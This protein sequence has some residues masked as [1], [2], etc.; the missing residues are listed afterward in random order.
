MGYGSAGVTKQEYGAYLAASIAYLMNRQRDAVGLLAFADRIVQH[1]PASGRPGHL[2]R[3]LLALDGLQAARGS[4]LSKPLDRLAEALSRRG[5]AVLISDLLDDPDAVIR[6]LRHLRFRGVDV[7][8]FHLLD[9]AELTFPFEN[10][11][12][13]RDL[14]SGAELTAVP[15]A[16]RERY[17]QEMQAF[18]ALYRRELQLAGID[19]CLVDTSQALDQA[20]L[21]YLSARSRRC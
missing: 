20:L 8:V 3:L 9:P 10:A 1:L 17:L 6:G 18:I 2:R 16:V 4:D 7:I 12:R 11:A 19:Y 5:M 21:A 13:F 14:E 15:S